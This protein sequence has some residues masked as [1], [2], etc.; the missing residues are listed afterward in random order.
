MQKRPSIEV[1][2][3]WLC[4]AA[5]VTGLLTGTWMAARANDSSDKT[6]A[7]KA[8]SN[9]VFEPGK[10]WKVH[11]TITSKEYE[12]M[13]P[14]GGW[15]FPGVGAAPKPKPP[16]KPEEPARQ[17]HRNTFG[18]DLPWA[19]GSATVNDE[20]F[21]D[22]GIRYKGNGTIGDAARTI[23]KSFKID[24]DHFGGTAQFH[25]TRTINLHCGVADPS[26]CRETLGY[27]LYRAAGV[28]ASRTALAEVWLTVPGKYDKELLGVYTVVEH[29]DKQFQRAHFGTDKGLLMKPEGLREFTYQGD[30]WD[31][32]KKQYAPKRDA[33]KEEASRVIAFSKLVHKAD[34]AE[35]KKQIASYLDVDAYLRYLAVTAF[36]ANADSFFSLGHN[37]YLYLHPRTG[38]FHFMPWDLDRA[39]ANLPVLGS[40]KQ[41]MD[42]SL[43]HP[44][45]GTHRLT[46]RLLA[47]PEVSEKYHNLLK[48]LAA[49]CFAKQRL[50]VELEALASATK[51]LIAQEWR[52]AEARG[53]SSS[54]FGPPA[55]F[56]TPPALKTF[57]DKRTESVALQLAGKSKGHVPS[58]SFRIG[59]VLAGPMMETLDTDK[60][61]SLSK[62][63][64]MA[65]VKK[66]FA[67]C[68]KDAE[69][70]VNEKGL[71]RALNEMFP[72]PPKAGP[73]AAPL[74][75][76]GI[77]N[78]MAGPIIRRADA[79]KDGK[80]TVDE[81]VAAGGKLFDEFDKGRIGKLDETVFGELLNALFPLPN[82]GP[83]GGKGG[84]P[85]KDDKNQKNR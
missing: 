68:E 42:L 2:V 78:F 56:G 79:D 18:V 72:K 38:Q 77:G 62:D 30:D 66:V 16:V 31:R 63:E 3:A 34:D 6:G 8:A 21:K 47:M 52:S 4:R 11:L 83:P 46:D 61:G 5:V 9:G 24:L 27:A 19:I 74:P 55:M 58:G 67:A 44:Y 39:F 81:L 22:V 26:R 10:V 7:E 14:R 20:T 80:V 36:V 28:P 17:V 57:V 54:D 85:K 29:V 13:Q 1:P 50:L 76:F 49:G 12:A 69:G 41:L 59:D 53:E 71:A 43:T 75:G 82:F 15:G 60:D 48:E 33:T 73:G 35:F 40:N 23:K 84:E 25:R 70:H 64:W 65:A 32:Y 51:D 37:Y 45:S